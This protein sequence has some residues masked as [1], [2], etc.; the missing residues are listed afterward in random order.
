M[1]IAKTTN[2]KEAIGAIEPGTD[3]F[4]LTFGQFSLIDAIVAIVDQIGP[5]DIV[6]SSW[7]AA[8]AHLE[9]TAEMVA[10]AEIRS[11]KMIIDRSF[12]TRQPKYCERM[13]R[14]FG[15]DCI[16]HVRSHAKF[17]LIANERFKIVIRTSMNLNEN[18]RLENIE[19]SENPEFYNFMIGIVNDI[20]SEVNPLE[21]RSRMLD[22]KNNPE[23]YPYQE[24]KLN[25]LKRKDYRE[26]AYT[27]RVPNER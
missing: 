2:A 10:S 11:L 12:E 17:V 4:I 18:P 21:K 24:M 5:A 3:T 25:R 6:L 20:F 22:L 9:R 7:T 27:H 13:R 14:L 19:I 16:R 8:D 23:N 15:T 1:R 26:P